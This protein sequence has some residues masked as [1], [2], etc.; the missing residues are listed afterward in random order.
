MTPRDL[1]RCA[2]ILV[3]YAELRQIRQV[4]TKGDSYIYFPSGNDWRR[5]YP[6]EYPTPAVGSFEE[7]RDGLRL[8]LERP[9]TASAVNMDRLVFQLR[10]L[11]DQLIGYEGLDDGE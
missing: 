6:F 4:K 7:D 5:P 3:D 8:L 1:L 9:E 10:L 2:E 11:S